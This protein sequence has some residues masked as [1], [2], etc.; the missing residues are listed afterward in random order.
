MSYTFTHTDNDVINEYIVSI[1]GP[2][3]EELLYH[4]EHFL[5]GCGYCFPPEFVGFDATYQEDIGG[6]KDGNT[7]S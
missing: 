6:K 2:T 3:W 7:F 5:K 4:F 1:D